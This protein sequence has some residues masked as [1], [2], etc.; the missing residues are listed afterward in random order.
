MDLEEVEKIFE[1]DYSLNYDIDNNFEGMK[2]LSKYSKPV[3]QAAEH[4]IVYYESVE[5]LIDKGMTKEEFIYRR[6]RLL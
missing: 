2:I 5:N 4:D 1:G 6:T 3:I